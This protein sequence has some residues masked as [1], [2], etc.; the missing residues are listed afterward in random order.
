MTPPEVPAMAA[1]ACGWIE[2]EVPEMLQAGMLERVDKWL[3]HG[4]LPLGGL[5]H[6]IVETLR[7]SGAYDVEL[8]ACRVMVSLEPMQPSFRL[9]LGQCLIRVGRQDEARRMLG[10]LVGL[11]L[12]RI[13]ALLLLAANGGLSSPQWDEL[14]ALLAEEGGWTGSHGAFIRG[15]V[16]CGM[17]ERAEAF[18]TQWT[19]RWTIAPT[20]IME[21][22]VIAMLLGQ[23]LKARGFFDPLW[24]DASDA[25][26][27]MVGRFDGTVR[28]YDD[29]IEAAL[30][31]RI[32][33]AFALDEENLARI[34]LPDHGPEALRVRVMMVT[35][36]DRALAN[37]FAV[38]FRESARIAGVDFHLHADSALAVPREFQGSD[39]EVAERLAFFESELERLRPD[40]VVIDCVSPLILRGLNPGILMDLKL[41]LGFKVVCLMRDSHRYAMALLSAWAP[42]CDAMAADILSP[43]FGPDHASFN[44]RVLPMVVPALH[45]AFLRP[46]HS[47]LD[48]VFI[49]SVN[50]V[51]RYALLS[52]LMTED[53]GFSA[54]IGERRA[55]EAPD[56]EAYARILSRASA[57]LNISVHTPEDHLVTGRVW[58]TIAAGSLLVEQDNPGTARFFQP[59]R[60]YLP[61]GSLEE[62]VH[63]AHFIKRQPRWAER[64]AAEAHGWATRWYG[65][66]AIWGGLL[67]RALTQAPP[68]DPE[69]ARA[70]AHAWMSVT[71]G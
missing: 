46:H 4:H 69:A 44:H 35:F 31:S 11:P 27:E 14:E 67:G 13:E 5:W 30:L 57:V 51:A 64:I 7:R 56:M 37:D 54:I 39:A 68:P 38:H 12:I 41:R 36:G 48:M 42:V 29:E 23:P 19:R 45:D 17:P 24:K 59:Y 40:V 9:R 71:F 28:P 61:W 50:F 33:A 8:A 66:K 58:E 26:A 2:D 34:V 18:M 21:M 16:A 15:M 62:I 47:D 55:K 3:A 70:A 22:G 20:Q 43:V 10:G 52:V 49:G 6:P 60:H 63:L 25:Q 1:I 53:I 32:E 65:P